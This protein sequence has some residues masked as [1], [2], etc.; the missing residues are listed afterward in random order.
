MK[1]FRDI[2]KNYF[3]KFF[4]GKAHS[5]FHPVSYIADR[6]ETMETDGGFCFFVNGFSGFVFDL[7]YIKIY[8]MLKNNFAEGILSVG[9]ICRHIELLFFDERAENKLHL[10]PEAAVF[11][12]VCNAFLL[13]AHKNPTDKVLLIMEMVIK[14]LATRSAM[15][16][17]VLNCYF[18]N[19]FCFAKFDYRVRKN[20]FCIQFK[21]KTISDSVLSRYII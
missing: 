15:V 11:P 7:I 19:G 21:Q 13:V 1:R 12:K 18:F 10:F 2:V 17:N 14:S 8:V 16:N 6:A 9:D 20:L 5:V 4:G 3:R